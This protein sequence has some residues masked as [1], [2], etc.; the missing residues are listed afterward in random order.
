MNYDIS[1]INDVKLKP[2]PLF[3]SLRTCSFSAIEVEQI[4]TVLD[5]AY[6][7]QHRQWTPERVKT[8]LCDQITIRKTF[9]IDFLD[10]KADPPTFKAS[11]I[12]ACGSIRLHEKYPGKGFINW[13]AVHPDHQGQGLAS[14]IV[15]TILKEFFQDYKFKEVALET[16]DTS[17]PAIVTY[18]KLGFLPTITD[19][20][21]EERWK[22]IFPLIGMSSDTPL[23]INNTQSFN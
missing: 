17:L 22:K 7:I 23:V 13:I 14:I 11:N 4:S 1:K 20:T 8:T 3:Y 10:P 6:G 15:F 12:V 21:H 2:L 16:Q 19:E 9:V 18:L 5:M